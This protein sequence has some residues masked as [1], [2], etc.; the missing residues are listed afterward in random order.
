M[1]RQRHRR[2]VWL[3]LVLAA[4]QG[5]VLLGYRWVEDRRH[6]AREPA[7]G[8]ERLEGR[9]APDLVLVA[10]DGSRRTLAELQGKPVLLHFWATWCP[11]CKEELP[12]LLALGR[13]LVQSGGPQLVAV[14]VDK[15]WDAVRTFLAGQIPP[16]VMRVDAA[17]AS[18]AYG[19]ATLPDTYL[20]GADGTLRLRF[21]GARDWRL[22]AAHAVL[23][24]ETK[25]R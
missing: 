5:L 23:R 2:V 16:E 13:E 8:Y 9:S 10:P 1:G 12:G 24:E 11:P 7:F 6:A 4:A 18:A 19:V 22:R 20:I 15:D 21:E 14:T 17:L 3:G 25:G